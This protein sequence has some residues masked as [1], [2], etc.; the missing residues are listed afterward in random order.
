MSRAFGGDLVIQASGFGGGG[1]S[2]ELAAA[3]GELPEVAATTG[4]CYGQVR[5]D[6]DDQDVTVADLPA[7]DGVLDLDAAEGSVYDVAGGSWPSAPT[8]PTTTTW[9]SV[10]SSARR[11]RTASEVDLTL[12]GTYEDTEL[13]GEMVL[14]SDI[15]AEHS[16]QVI[17]SHVLVTLADGVSIDRGEQAV[18]AVADDF[19]KPE[20]MDRRGVHRRRHAPA[21][22][23][24]SPSST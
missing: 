12:G 17:D 10:T 9:P 13:V 22:T 15:W 2:P 7:L 16:I 11:S 1:L 4:M 5:I 20:V 6:A 24:C 3:V 19:G 18:Q 14:P 23:G 21:S 8:T